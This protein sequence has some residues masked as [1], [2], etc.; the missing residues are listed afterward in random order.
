MY[1]VCWNV[2]SPAQGCT[3]ADILKAFDEAIYDGVDL[4]SLSL[5]SDVPVFSD[6]DPRE[7]IALGSFRAVARGIPVVVA[8]GNAGPHAQTVV[9]TS[10]W[11]LTVAATTMDRMFPTKITLGNNVTILVCSWY[12]SL[13][14]LISSENISS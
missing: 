5:G 2:P 8:A 11:V 3:A 7:G 13:M 12:S 9:N 4:L 1:K 14:P 10:P 6:V